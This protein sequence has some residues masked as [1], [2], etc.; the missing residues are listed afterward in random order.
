MNGW[1]GESVSVLYSGFALLDGLPLPI[2]VFLLVL[3][4]GLLAVS[5]LLR[6]WLRVKMQE[7]L[8]GVSVRY[9]GEEFLLEGS[10]N[11]FGAKLPGMGRLRGN[12]MIVLTWRR[13]V[14]RMALPERWVEIPLERVMGVEQRRVFMGKS[15]GGPLLVVKF[16]N[17]EGE[18]DTCAWAVKDVAEWARRLE[19]LR[20]QS[21]STRL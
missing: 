11:F 17:E 8:K 15:H 3:V 10:A 18:E 12:G 13:L 14:F 4:G 2:A 19:G 1:C 20:R 6:V 16:L 5:L 21:R 9:P 7:A